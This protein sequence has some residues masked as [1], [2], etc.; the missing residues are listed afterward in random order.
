MQESYDVENGLGAL[1]KR[2]SALKAKADRPII[3]NIAGGSASGK[4]SIVSAQVM[5]A[6][7]GE[8]I[9]ISM[10]DYLKGNAYLKA[11]KEKGREI[12]FDHPDH[13]D[14]PLLAEHVGMLRDSATID[15]PIFSFK[16]QERVGTEKVVPSK[17]II[18]E[19]IFALHEQ[20]VQLSDVKVFVDA[21]AHGR[22]A[23]RI[24]RDLKRTAWTPS[25][26][27]EYTSTVVESTYRS[28]VASTMPAADIVILNDY[29]PYKETLKSDTREIQLKF[30][31]SESFKLPEILSAQ[32]VSQS[33]QH[34]DYYMSGAADL[35]KSDEIIRVRSESGRKIFTYK[36]PRLGSDFIERSNITFEIDTKAEAGL[37]SLYGRKISSVI[38]ERLVYKTGSGLELCIDR[39]VA[40][41]EGGKVT[42]LGNFLNA[43]VSIGSE[44]LLRDL[45]KSFV[46]DSLTHVD[47]SY[48]NM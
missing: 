33:T 42:E 1:I 11:E 7:R 37:T 48:Y 35:R 40:K 14:T 27:L 13:T 38:K 39:N 25:F 41:S 16:A 34:D 31:I 44:N 17:I 19:G 30:K 6:F 10:D 46:V 3:V 8:S 21:S 22:F 2:I 18:I 29:D 20:L 4:S 24:A 26:I 15:K 36:G 23:R 43:R 12:N 9:L 5:Q 28:N 45:Q 47:E 32:L